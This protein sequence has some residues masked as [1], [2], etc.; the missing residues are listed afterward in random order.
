MNLL[1]LLRSINPLDLKGSWK[2]TLCGIVAIVSL[3]ASEFELFPPEYQK[4]VNFVGVVALGIGV[5]LA[6]DAD[7]RSEDHNLPPPPPPQC[8]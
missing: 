1:A 6:R 5:M 7:K 4:H 2:T 8:L 3:A